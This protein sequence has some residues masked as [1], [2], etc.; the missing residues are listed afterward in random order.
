[1]L[2]RPNYDH[3]TT[4][5]SNARSVEDDILTT[6]PRWRYKL[7]RSAIHVSRLINLLLNCKFFSANY[8]GHKAVNNFSLPSRSRILVLS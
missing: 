6:F 1:M 5:A 4:N 2:W 8:I 7:T 3:S